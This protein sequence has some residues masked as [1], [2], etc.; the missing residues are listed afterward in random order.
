MQIPDIGQKQGAMLSIG[1]QLKCSCNHF[2]D[3]GILMNNT[4]EDAFGR[5]CLSGFSSLE[6]GFANSVAVIDLFPFVYKHIQ[7]NLNVHSG[8]QGRAQH[9]N[10]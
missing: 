10:G 9:I 1:A 2:W 3:D 4:F 8:R 6:A 7:R 5:V